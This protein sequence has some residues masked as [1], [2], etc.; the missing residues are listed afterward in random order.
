M[1]SRGAPRSSILYQ[2]TDRDITLVDIP[3]SIAVAQDRSAT[4]LSTAPLK[5]PIE[6]KEDYQPKS[7]KAKANTAHEHADGAQ[8]AEYKSLIEQALGH[9][10]THVSRQWCEPRILL[11]AKSQEAMEIDDPEKQLESRLRQWAACKES[12]GDD[13]AFDIQ[14]M[15]A[16]LGATCEHD[17]TAGKQVTQGWVTSYRPA[18]EAMSGAQVAETVARDEPKEPWT[19]SFHNPEVFSLDMSIT[20]HGVHDTQLGP[21]YRFTIPPRSTFFLS[22][23]THSDA[24]RASF[25]ELT[26]EYT[27]PRHF[28][29]VLLDPPWPNRSAKRKGAY[30]QVGGMPYLKRM[31]LRMDLDNYLEHNALVGVWI[32]NKEALREHVLGPGGLFETWNVG[33][34]EEWIWIKTTTKGEP[35]FDID[36]VLR[37]PYEIL[38]LG[39][40]APNSWTTMTHA[41]TIKRRVIAA[42]P[43]MHSRKPCLK[44]LLELYMPDPTDYSALEVFSRYLVSGWTS[45]GNEVLKYNWD[46]Y[47]SS[48]TSH[49][50]STEHSLPLRMA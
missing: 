22:D 8:H 1:A 40:A 28:D 2:N 42:V 5:A 3:T 10:R 41:P 48:E 45:W 43:D 19:S 49:E 25:R 24:F 23:S 30:E 14:K 29:L 18:R 46:F 44:E 39:R 9:I 4:L 7:Q 50:A 13:A 32:T 20:E 33:L 12:K 17:A 47:W 38:L 36:T 16:S 15:M 6:P 21:E 35:M 27:L 26:D 37:K 11:H 31:L 34:I